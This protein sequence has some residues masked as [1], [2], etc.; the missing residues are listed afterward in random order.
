MAKERGR[1]G[2]KDSQSE[3]GEQ[4]LAKNRQSMRSWLMMRKF[5]N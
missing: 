4:R 1:R 3:G 5:R 2:E